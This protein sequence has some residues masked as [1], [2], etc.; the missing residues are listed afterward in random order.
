MKTKIT[1]A[2]IAFSAVIST[3]C[4]KWLEISNS[5]EI[6]SEQQF[7]DVTGFRDAVVGVYVKLAKPE[8][9]SMEMTWRTAE[10]LSQQYAVVASAPDLNVPKYL[11]NTAPL[12]AKRETIWAGAYNAIANINQILEYHEKN[13]S[14]FESAPITDSLI[15]GEMLALRAFLHFDMLRLFGKGNLGARPNLMEEAAIPY[16]TEFTRIATNQRSYRETLGLLKKDIAEAIVYLQADPLSKLRGPAAYYSQELA[17]G[18][19]ST[20]STGTAS[21]NRKMRMNYWAA[22]ALYARILLWEGTS[23]SKAEALKQSL[24]VIGGSALSNGLGEGDGAYYTWTASNELDKPQWMLNNNSFVNEHLFTLNVEKLIDIE[25]GWFNAYSPNSTYS[26]VFLTDDR[27]KLVFESPSPIFAI[28]YRG[29]Q[30]LLG[31]GASLTNFAITKFYNVAAVTTG[32]ATPATPATYNNRIPLMRV[33]E[34]FY[35]AAE[36]LL[37]PGTNYDRNKAV[38]LLNKVRNQ[39]N[40]IATY[41]LSAA[42]L[43][44]AEIRNEITKEYMKE[45]IAEGQL[46]FY[47]KRLGFTNIPGYPSDMTDAEYQM[48]MPDSEIVNG[49]R[50]N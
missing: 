46:F 6:I 43:T 1:I 14:V 16:V 27:R 5:S 20:S 42:S 48:P 15:K 38:A 40:I 34:M 26:V 37:E 28:D 22:K 4:K 2:I 13:R 44:D 3:S 25:A 41:N 45:F 29:N 36:C 11:W 10:F 39:R 12:P 23:E 21:P 30:G 18:F 31:M 47:Y 50:I 17:G 33:T 19:I 24:E 7:S 49:G 9:Y 32:T 8:L 35:I